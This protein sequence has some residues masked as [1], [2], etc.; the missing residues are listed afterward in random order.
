MGENVFKL[1]Q[2]IAKQTKDLAKAIINPEKMKAEETSK[3]DSKEKKETTE[4]KKDEK[5]DA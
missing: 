3:D 5:T 1:T 2:I 4:E